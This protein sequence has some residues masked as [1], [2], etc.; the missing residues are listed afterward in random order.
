MAMQSKAFEF[1][2]FRL[3]LRERR[4][5]RDGYSVPLQGK[6]FDTLYVLVSRHGCLVTK[7]EL[8][9]AVWPD[10]V[11]EESNLNHNICILR[12][13]LGEKVTGQKYIETVPRQGYRF[14]AEVRELGG[15][16]ESHLSTPWQDRPGILVAHHPEASVAP[17]DSQ[18]Q[19]ATRAATQKKLPRRTNWYQLLGT[20]ALLAVPAMLLV[21]YIG[22]GRLGI[23]GNP[24]NSRMVV[25]VLPFENLTGDAGQEYVADGLSHE[26]IAQL[27]R[28]NTS[29]VG[30]I[31]RTSTKV[32]QGVRKSIREIGRELGVDYVVEG[33]VRR[34]GDRYR[35]T[36]LLIRV[37][38]QAH[39][40]A[41]NFDR[42][43]DS[44]TALQVEVAKAVTSEIGRRIAIKSDKN[45]YLSYPRHLHQMANEPPS[46]NALASPDDKPCSL[47]L[48]PADRLSVLPENI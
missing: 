22:A 35:I 25:A 11:V 16:N 27:G 31:A 14:V 33:S 20:V 46:F 24:S 2:P 41:A 5:T 26:I 8:M 39:L 3:D 45:S 40:W 12:R 7:D 30:V 48:S 10:S 43:M 47:Y 32:Y 38:D 36:V 9:A 44:V 29:R 1:G 6:V 28:W 18:P 17:A 15:P 21:A 13:A 4:L 23:T 37:E 34:D 19:S 42:T